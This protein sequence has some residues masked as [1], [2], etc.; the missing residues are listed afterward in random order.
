M[1]ETPQ[2]TIMMMVNDEQRFALHLI[3]NSKILS[4]DRYAY[5]RY[6]YGDSNQ[7]IQFGQELCTGF[8]EKYH[9]FILSSNKQFMAISSPRSIVPPA[10][11]Y[12]FQTFLEKL[13]RFLQS[14][15]RPPALEHTIQRIG[16]IAEDYSSLSRGERFDRLIDERYSIDSQP[17]TNKFLLFIDDIRITGMHEMNIIRL[18]NASQIYNARL[19]IYYAQLINDQIPSSFEHELNRCAIDNLEQL[20][21]IIHNPAASFQINTRVLKEILRSNL[22]ELDQFLHSI[23]DD[24]ISKIYY[25]C[26]A[27]NYET[28]KIFA[29][30][31]NYM[32]R[33][34]QQRQ[35]E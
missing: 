25:A 20:L 2:E 13:N 28:I 9:D 30:S 34:L 1:I 27:C 10:A 5:S 35:N 14:N 24:L 8:L 12:I 11:Y 16:T 22:S 7:A 32:H 31:L 3:N 17:L 18:L 26:L 33:C 15:G 29:D 23:S 4:F 6:K 19:F 21:T